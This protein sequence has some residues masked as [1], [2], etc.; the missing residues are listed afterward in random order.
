ML[1]AGGKGA[2]NNL[3][4]HFKIIILQNIYLVFVPKVGSQ[5]KCILN[6]NSAFLC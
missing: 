5:E 4:H 2:F 6:M 3:N 1:W